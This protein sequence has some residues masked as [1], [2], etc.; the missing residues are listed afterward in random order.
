MF[1]LFKKSDEQIK[2][3]QNQ[4]ELCSIRTHLKRAEE[5]LF[6]SQRTMNVLN[7]LNEK[8]YRVHRDIE[9]SL[10]TVNDFASINESFL[11]TDEDIRK[12]HEYISTRKNKMEKEH[13][14]NQKHYFLTLAAYIKTEK[15]ME[16]F[17]F[18]P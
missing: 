11:L 12:T 1:N 15:K 6:T 5:K 18:N 4:D 8:N 7:G 14:E 16:C 2:Y 3:E 17:K 13:I 9:H 10:K